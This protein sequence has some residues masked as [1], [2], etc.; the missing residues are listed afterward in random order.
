MAESVSIAGN[1]HSGPLSVLMP[2]GVWGAIVLLWFWFTSLRALYD[3]YRHGDPAFRTINIFLFAYFLTKVFMFLVIFGAIE[4][5]LA[6]FAV[7]IGLSISINGGICR[8]AAVKA[9]VTANSPI[10]LPAPARPR[11][12]PFFPR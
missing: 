9:R 4:G 6:S 11:L 8:R 3:N 2:L 5:D 12:Q 1:Y 10:P 7:L